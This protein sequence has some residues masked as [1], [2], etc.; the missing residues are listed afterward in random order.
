M[1]VLLAAEHVAS[2][3]QLKVERGDAESGAQFAELLHGGEAFAGDVGERGVRRDEEIGVGALGGT[4]DAAAQLVELGESQAVG[5]VDQNR[6]GAGDVQTVFNDGGGH[7]HI[8]FIANEFQHH[9]FEFF[10]GHLAVGHH[11]ARLGHQF[12]D[13]GSERIDRFDTIV[14]EEDLAVAS[15]FGFDG[16]LHQLFLK[17]GDDGLNGQTVARRRFDD[18]HVAKANERHVQGAWN[19][20][21][22]ERERVHVFAHFLEALFVGYAEALLFI[23]DEKTEVGE[24]H[25]FRKQA[26]RADDHVHLARFQIRENLFLLRRAAETAEHFDARGESGESFLERFEMLEG[27]HSGRRENGNLLVVHDGLERRAHGDFCFA[28]A[29][30]ATQQA[31]HGLGA[32]HVALDVADGGDLIGGFLK[33][34][35]IFKFAL[36]IAVR[37]KGK[38]RSGFALGVKREKLVGHVFDG[39]ARARFASVPDGAAE[40]VQWR[41]RALEHA[42]TL[43][44]VHTFQGNVETRIVG[45]LQQ[46]ELAAMPVGCDLAKTLKLPDAVIHMDHIV[47]GLQFGKI[48]EETGSPNFAAGALDRGRDV[49]KIGV[50]EKSKPS[51][52]KG[53]AFGKR[54]A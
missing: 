2:A 17:G 26:M 33:F 5:T 32:F 30:V 28:V 46:H 42:V 3:A 48:A 44:E 49:E 51:A 4:T 14:N 45:I 6:V 13:H 9:A 43:D 7:Q 21:G 37:R 36:E 41:M 52:G 40:S 47:T 25:V 22:G 20:R 29:D 12:R 38:A 19:G 15:K 10:F 23:D 34:E 11:D 18:G 24:F 31:V 54:R 53:D 16:A 50:A 1:S 35:G 27:E 39:F 8:R